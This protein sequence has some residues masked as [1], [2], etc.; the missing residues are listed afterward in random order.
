M[1]KYLVLK[2]LKIELRSKEIVT[3]MFIFG[4]SVTLIFALAFQVERNII[5]QFAPGLLW[6]IIL[7][8]SVLGLNRLFSLENEENALWSWLSAPVDRGTVYLSKLISSLIFVLSSEILLIIPFFVFLNLS[9][10]FSFLLFGVILLLGSISILTIGC[11][12]SGITLQAGMRDVLIPILLF[13]LS[14]P[15]IIAAIK[16]TES[17]FSQKQFIEWNFWLL[18][19]G[20]F[21]VIFGLFGYLIFSRIVED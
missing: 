20:T 15:I 19:L 11:V 4:V 1:L 7:F 14:T 10:D 8:T 17:L 21:S 5:L 9:I 2:D 6:I 13:P 12:I 18:M 16:C 3:S